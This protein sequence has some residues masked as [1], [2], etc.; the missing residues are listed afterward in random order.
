MQ[1]VKFEFLGHKYQLCTADD[2]LSVEEARL[3][4]TGKRYPLPGWG[5]QPKCIL[6]LGG[7]VGEFSVLC[8]IRF[9]EARVVCVEPNPWIRDLL[10]TNAKDFVFEVREAA[11]GVEH[12]RLPY[13]EC[14]CAPVANSMCFRPDQ[15]GKSVEVDV[16]PIGEL[17]GLQPDIIKIDIEGWEGDV[18]SKAYSDNWWLGDVKVI[19][20]E[21]H[22]EEDRRRIDSE[23]HLSHN[24]W[25]AKIDFHEQGELMYVQREYGK[26]LIK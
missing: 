6:D 8:K 23:L 2:C 24:L 16:I 1:F 4:L 17:M 9:P 3:I 20:V 18:L 26:T 19:Y 12:G 25:Q 5:F 21:F 13:Y 10:A 14:S 15:T 11:V 7:Y 22:T